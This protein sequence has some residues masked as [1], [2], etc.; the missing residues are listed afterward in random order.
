MGLRD[1]LEG[2]VTKRIG[3]KGK[4]LT[5]K[6]FELID[7][8][9]IETNNDG[10]KIKY[11]KQPPN[12][13]AIIYALDRVLGKPKQYV[14]RNDEKSGIVLV[15][16]VIRNLANSPYGKN[17]SKQF[18]REIGGGS[19]FIEGGSGGTVDDDIGFVEC[20]AARIG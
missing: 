10:K 3:K 16:H 5:D 6:L 2:K 4:Y 19:S 20:D 8:I 11:Y 15:E 18:N 17:G 1:L 7:G 14:E 9:Y 12:L 13:Q